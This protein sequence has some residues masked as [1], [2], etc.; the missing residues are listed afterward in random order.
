MPGVT[1]FVRNAT[2]DGPAIGTVAILACTRTV[3]PR[4]LNRGKKGQEPTCTPYTQPLATDRGGISDA[5]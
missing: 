2:A 5:A 1:N 4:C 3:C